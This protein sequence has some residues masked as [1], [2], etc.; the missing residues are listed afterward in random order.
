MSATR[1]A[2]QPPA[3]PLL[4]ARPSL[5]AMAASR[6]PPSPSFPSSRATAPGRTS[7][8]PPSRLRRRRGQGL[9]RETSDR[10]GGGAGRRKG[11]ESNQQLASRRDPGRHL[12]LPRCH[13]GAAYHAG[14]RRLPLAERGASPEAGPLR[15]RSAGPVLPRSS[16]AGQ[17]SP[18]RQYGDL[19]GEHRGHLCR[20]RVQGQE[21]RGQTGDQVSA[22]GDGRPVHP[23]PREQRHRDQA[24]FRGG[25]EATDPLCHRICPGPEVRERHPGA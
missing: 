23:L 13:Q 5:S 1:T 14:W 18:R 11:Q 22:G 12:P 9:R 4:K 24:D 20:N 25:I 16:L 17:G 19:P 15:L 7:G 3:R 8:A 21:R 10:L 2:T 6:C